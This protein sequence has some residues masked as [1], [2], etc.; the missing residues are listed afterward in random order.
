V[1]ARGSQGEQWGLPGI[2]K[3]RAW[4]TGP[5]PPHQPGARQP[6]GSTGAAPAPGTGHLPGDRDG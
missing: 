3:G 1:G 4:Q 6:E 5:V 2:H